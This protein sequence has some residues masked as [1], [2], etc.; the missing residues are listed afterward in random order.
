M[1]LWKSNIFQCCA[2]DFVPLRFPCHPECLCWSAKT[3]ETVC[4]TNLGL[5]SIHFNLRNRSGTFTFG[6]IN[7]RYDGLGHVRRI[8]Y[9]ILLRKPKIRS[10]LKPSGC[11]GKHK[12]RERRASHIWD[13]KRLSKKKC[14]MLHWW[15]LM[16]M[17]NPPG[18]HL[19]HLGQP[20]GWLRCH[21]VIQNFR[22]HCKAGRFEGFGFEGF[23]NCPSWILACLN[24]CLHRCSHAQGA[25]GCWWYLRERVSHAYSCEISPLS[26]RCTSCANCRC[27]LG[28]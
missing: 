23:L 8:R 6:M 17:W 26:T 18:L 1:S 15:P 14:L 5:R 13:M 9:K 7:V 24:E 19:R 22:C 3:L 11:P 2:C 10:S 25:R 27:Q 21:H 20:F 12:G 28:S 16:L 4:S